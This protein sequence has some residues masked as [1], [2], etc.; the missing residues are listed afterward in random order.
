MNRQKT[1]AIYLSMPIRSNSIQRFGQWI[2]STPQQAE[3]DIKLLDTPKVSIMNEN[4]L[5]QNLDAMI[6]QTHVLKVI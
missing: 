3:G 5:Q 1:L 4:G 6:T 2:H